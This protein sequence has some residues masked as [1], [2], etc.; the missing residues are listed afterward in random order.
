MIEELRSWCEHDVPCTYEKLDGAIKV[1]W[2][3]KSEKSMS[4]E[5]IPD[6]DII[7]AIESSIESIGGS[8][9]AIGYEQ[10]M[11]EITPETQIFKLGRG[12]WEVED[13][14]D[15]KQM[16]IDFARGVS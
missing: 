16:A 4:I 8:V 15:A 3:D 12:K 5:G 9:V 6:R 11:E 10:V 7:E 1:T 14:F 2:P 13:L